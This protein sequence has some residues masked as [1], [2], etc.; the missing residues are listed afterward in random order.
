MR[1][2]PLDEGEKEM[3]L[4]IRKKKKNLSPTAQKEPAHSFTILL[5][6]AET[7]RHRAEEAK[8]LAMQSRDVWER[9]ILLR[10][11]TQMQLLAA[12]GRWMGGHLIT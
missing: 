6:T 2:A 12:Q 1:S 8:R 9:E 7:Y 10:V 3:R 4:A 11:A 5:P